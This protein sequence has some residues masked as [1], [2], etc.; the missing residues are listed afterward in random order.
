MHKAAPVPTT[1][2]SASNFLCQMVLDNAGP[3][4][5]QLECTS[6]LQ[7]PRSGRPTKAS[8]DARSNLATAGPG[9]WPHIGLKLCTSM[10]QYRM[11]ALRSQKWGLPAPGNFIYSP[12]ALPFW[13]Q[14]A[15]STLLARPGAV[16]VSSVG[17]KG[18]GGCRRLRL[19]QG[20]WLV[21]AGLKGG[22]GFTHRLPQ[23]RFLAQPCTATAHSLKV[24]DLQFVGTVTA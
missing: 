5:A 13:A 7:Q 22:V 17:F 3:Q 16:P 11:H 20:S 4:L 9:S 15:A 2:G 14:S 6:T 1:H 23:H 8:P 12:A 10:I 24:D 19:L 18:I 21:A